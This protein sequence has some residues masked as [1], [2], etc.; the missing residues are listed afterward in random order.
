MTE[1]LNINNNGAHPNRE[2]GSRSLKQ[3]TLLVMTG[4]MLVVMASGCAQ[5]PKRFVLFGEQHDQIDQKTQVALT[6]AQQ[7]KTHHLQAVVLEMAERGRNTIGLPTD[8]EESDVQQRL[9]WHETGWPWSHY[10]PVV[11]T[12]VRAGIPVV[13]GNLPK[14]EQKIA[15]NESRLD[16]LVTPQV[17]ALIAEAVS[18][19]HCRSLPP[20]AVTRMVRI[21]IARDDTMAQTLMAEAPQQPKS[22]VLLLA[23]E[24]HVASDRGVPQ[25]LMRRGITPQDIHSVGFNDGDLPLDERL[26]ATVTPRPDPCK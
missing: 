18:T 23:G 12:A 20:E 26:H 15:A 24:Q 4:L 13:G 1:L 25:H 22:T 19:S 17:H 16:N 11:M 7:A 9:H 3:R 2:D 14:A 10:G 6:I 5:S 21:Q 8:A